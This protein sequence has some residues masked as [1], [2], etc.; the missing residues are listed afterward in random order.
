MNNRFWGIILGMLGV[1]AWLGIGSLVPNFV[2]T[3]SAEE[4]RLYPASAILET[5]HVEAFDFMGNTIFSDQDLSKICLPYIQRPVS[6]LE[7]DELRQKLTEHYTQ[8]G[9][10]NSGAI[11][12]DQ[13]VTGGIVTYRIIEGKVSNL[14][15]TTDGR[16]RR[17]YIENHLAIDSA[18]PLN[19]DAL[20]E[21][22]QLLHQNPLIQKVTMALAPGLKL[23]ES[24]VK[25]SVEE[26]NPFTASLTF[27]NHR[28]PSIGEE[29][30]TLSAAYGNL[31]GWGDRVSGSFG[32][33]QGMDDFSL[34]Y[35]FPF[36]LMGRETAVILHF[37]RNDSQMVEAPFDVIDIT[38]QGIRWRLSL[39]QTLYQ[40]PTASFLVGIHGETRHSET[41]L[42]GIPYAFSPGVD[43]MTGES[44]VT[45]LRLYQEWLWR[46]SKEVF[47]AYSTFSRGINALD[48]TINPIEP[49]SR[50]FSWLFQCQWVRRLEALG[51]SQLIL[52]ASGQLSRDPLLPMEKFSIGGR[53]TVRGYRENQSVRDNGVVSSVELR[54]PVCHL[55]PP[56]LKNRRGQDDRRDGEGRKNLMIAPFFDYGRAWNKGISYPPVEADAEVDMGGHSMNNDSHISDTDADAIYSIGVGLLWQPVESFQAELY[57]GHG[58]KDIDQNGDTLQEEG[59]HFSIRYN[60]L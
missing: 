16:L 13:K 21:R 41:T 14:E 34:A 9:Y 33:T 50:F 46:S 49:D 36:F 55:S 22:F 3:A 7:L 31:T 54:V 11:L 43:P 26:E 38:G 40:T 53:H 2:Q 59:V 23:G 12:P 4:D 57:W 19:I 51:G 10:I 48:A 56:L 30:L 6:F 44:D 35:R 58:L 15:I 29:R 47:S 17:S 52:K 1:M 27:D 25:A 37:D 8:N 20:Y 18:L 42:L 24:M 5:L 39:E 32:L 60:F 45:V 28:S